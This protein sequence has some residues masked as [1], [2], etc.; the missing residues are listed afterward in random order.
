MFDVKPITSPINLDCGATC[1]EMLLDY[2]GIDVPL[3]DLIVECHTRIIGCSAKDLI[4]VGRAHGLDMIAYKMDA[5]ELVKQDRPAIVW[6]RYSHWCV[7]C[8]QDDAGNVV[9][10]NPDRGRYRMSKGIFA[11]FYTGVSLWNGEP[12]DIEEVGA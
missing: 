12:H 4:R 3:D 5:E 8:G 2:Y 6:W 10:C 9:I 1:M 11:S 7:F